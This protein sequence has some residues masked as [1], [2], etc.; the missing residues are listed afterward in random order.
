MNLQVKFTCLEC[1]APGENDFQ[2]CP[3]CRAHAW[4]VEVPLGFWHKDGDSTYT[5]P[6]RE[7]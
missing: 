4:K 1:G 2:V 3:C 5:E 6:I 7:D